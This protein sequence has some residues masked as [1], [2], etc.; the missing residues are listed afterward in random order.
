M[1]EDFGDIPVGLTPFDEWFTSLKIIMI[2]AKFITFD[3]FIG[4]TV[5]REHFKQY[6]DVGYSPQEAF[7]EDLTAYGD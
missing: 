6:F 3:D 1:M 7:E 5:D 2:K 4:N